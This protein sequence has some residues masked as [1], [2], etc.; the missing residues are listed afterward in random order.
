MV[1]TF[2]H[3]AMG[4]WHLKLVRYKGFMWMCL[5]EL[6]G[7]FRW[8]AH[9]SAQPH[10]EYVEW[11]WLPTPSGVGALR[12][13]DFVLILKLFLGEIS[14]YT[15][16][17]LSGDALFSVMFLKV[18][19]NEFISGGRYGSGIKSACYSSRGHEFGVWYPIPV[20]YCRWSFPVLLAPK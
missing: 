12:D 3:L 2:K 7:C 5:P 18:I 20:T 11:V 14:A 10:G 17:S 6:C 1:G 9:W 15:W 8:V 16:I 4:R 19:T 13:V